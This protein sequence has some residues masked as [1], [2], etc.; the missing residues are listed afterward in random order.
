M[1]H[2]SP[3]ETRYGWPW[4]L[5]AGA[6]LA[7]I[8]LYAAGATTLW[9]RDEPRNARG[10]VEML[11]SGNWLYPTVNG[12]VRAHKPILTYWLMAGG[13]SVLGPTELAVRL[14]SVAGLIASCLLT[15]F[16]GRR[17]FG[18]RAG[19][20]GMLVLACNP[21]AFA[22][23][24]LCTT[25][26]VLL[27]FLTGA[28]AC[29]VAS[30]TRGTEWWHLALLAFCI[31]GAMLT[32]GPLGLAPLAVITTAL[33]LGRKSLPL[34]RPYFLAALAATAVGA[35]IFLAWAI[36]ANAAAGG[37][38]YRQGVGRHIIERSTEPLESHGGN[39]LLWLPFYLPVV[40]VGF[41]PWLLHLPAGL[42][43]T[44]GARLGGDD[45]RSR[46]ACRAILLA[47]VLPV[48]VIMSLAATKLAHYIL[49]IWPG[50]ALIVG[51]TIASW[52]GGRCTRADRRWML[53]MAWPLTALG[54]LGGAAAIAAPWLLHLDNLR[55]P[56]AILG[57]LLIEMAILGVREHLRR[58]PIGSAQVLLVSS[59][60][61]TLAA[62]VAVAPA[63]E[64]YKIVPDFA[65]RVAALVPAGEPIASY[66]FGE[67][68][69]NFYLG[70]NIEV[71]P[72]KTPPAEVLSWL[73]AANR[74]ALIVTDKRLEMLKLLQD[75]DSPLNTRIIAT[76]S[77][78]LNP[79]KMKPL[80]L[81][82]LR[83]QAPAA[84]PTTL[85]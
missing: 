66:G 64:E 82:A 53:H 49:P 60:V 4:V 25:D 16:I 47:I 55:M 75:V 35:A 76:S 58:G 69:L 63:V 29:F 17:L 26:A 52:D 42:S 37:E 44:L 77:E 36:P 67:A 39:W 51:A 59:A 43:M 13:V 46:R 18:R 12:A 65:R 34:G 50:L 28:T 78:G 70:R 15:Y 19:F 9:D 57:A 11:H 73:N 48:F 8:Y 72:D 80:R 54:L 68:S 74:G 21:L 41:L 3:S 30:V 14:H 83:R 45:E 27:A 81:L 1:P 22:C 71:F 40:I 61:L 7:G 6:V 85:P 2:G 79:A 38:F 32:K 84:P 62:A 24:T 20:W 10:V 23:G 56:G 5:A 33:L 31:A